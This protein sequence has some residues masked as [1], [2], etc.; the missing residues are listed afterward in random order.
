MKQKETIKLHENHDIIRK[1]S[2]LV[3]IISI[4]IRKE[5]KKWMKNTSREIFF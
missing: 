1:T 3:T 2:Y 5:G 4:N